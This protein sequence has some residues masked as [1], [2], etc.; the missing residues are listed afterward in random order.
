MTSPFRLSTH[1]RLART[2]ADR[3][4][5]LCAA[6]ETETEP[7]QLVYCAS[8]LALSLSELNH[9]LRDISDKIGEALAGAEAAR[10]AT[11]ADAAAAFAAE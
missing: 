11:R 7:E 2:K 4:K 3:I 8:Q 5:T 9:D 6:L 1:A 10:E